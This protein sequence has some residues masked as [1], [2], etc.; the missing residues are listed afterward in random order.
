MAS[1][2]IKIKAAAKSGAR[3]KSKAQ[4]KGR[5]IAFRAAGPRRFVVREGVA[6]VAGLKL[7]K[8]VKA[9]AGTS[10][11]R[12]RLQ[13]VHSAAEGMTAS[14]FKAIQEAL[15]VEAAAW[16]RLLALPAVKKTTGTRKPA[17]KLSTL[18]AE[19]VYLISAVI[20]RAMDVL[21]DRDAALEWLTTPSDLFSGK[22]P[23]QLLNTSTGADLVLD[24]LVRMEH[25]VYS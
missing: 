18:Q 19:Q 20:V 23:M 22:A 3:A 5:V 6:R 24:Q 21:E 14:E 25:G 10:G 11:V 4:A 9:Y 8:A 12:S 16:S 17:P 15:P 2:T 7:P 13:L 1:K